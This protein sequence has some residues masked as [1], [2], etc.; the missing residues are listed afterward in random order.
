MELDELLEKI[1]EWKRDMNNCD[2]STMKGLMQKTINAGENVI[3]NFFKLIDIFCQNEKKF[4]KCVKTLQEIIDTKN[5][6]AYVSLC[7]GDIEQSVNELKKEMKCD[8]MKLKDSKE[9]KDILES[10]K[11]KSLHDIT[12]ELDDILFQVNSNMEA[13]RQKM[14]SSIELQRGALV[15]LF[16]MDCLLFTQC[17]ALVKEAF[18]YHDYGQWEKIKDGVFSEIKSMF[19]S[20]NKFFELSEK[21]A[22]IVNLFDIKE[23]KKDFYTTTESN[24]AKIEGQINALAF[25]KLYIDELIQYYKDDK[26]NLACN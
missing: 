14:L 22:N 20:L 6:D 16:Q 3:L 21:I 12:K 17:F 18:N 4:N 13:G 24:I 7:G 15:C 1:E 10:W 2:T 23:I 9:V 25:V 5:M 26:F 19:L 11:S 8:E